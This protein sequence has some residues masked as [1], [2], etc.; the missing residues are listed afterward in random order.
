MK[1]KCGTC[2]AE[3]DPQISSHRPGLDCVPNLATQIATLTS[4]LHKQEEIH[5]ID[6]QRV[7]DKA[8]LMEKRF[9]AALRRITLLEHPNMPGLRI[10]V[11]KDE[12]EGL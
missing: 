5:K 2:S 12:K 8:D 10:S 1:V 4:E 7:V 6:F 11:A 9:A 3:Y